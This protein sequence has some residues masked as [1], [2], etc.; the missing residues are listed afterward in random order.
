MA[1]MLDFLGA[2]DEAG[3]ITAAVQDVIADP[4]LST[5]EIGDALARAVAAHQAERAS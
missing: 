5:S 3:R 4:G 1:M 2:A